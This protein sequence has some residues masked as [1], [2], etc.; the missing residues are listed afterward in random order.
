[1]AGIYKIEGLDDCIKCMDHAPQ[2]VLKMTKTAMK[3]AGKATTRVIRSKT[4]PRF[5]RLAGYKVTKGQLSGNTYALVGYFNK[6][7][8]KGSN[9]EIP[10]WFKA[11]WKN[12]GTITKRD[13]GHTFSN[14]VK[15]HVQGRRN[16]VGQKAENF[17]EAAL[18][19]W[20]S[21]FYEAFK[22]SM[23]KQENTLYDR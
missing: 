9:K 15:A 17:F 8:K 10:D 14:G 22:Q 13:P 19:G 20:D 6:S 11:Y 7:K 3:D 2:N 1:M 16:N 23:I 5:K 4:P 12:Y 21:V 18:P